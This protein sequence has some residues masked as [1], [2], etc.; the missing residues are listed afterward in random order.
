MTTLHRF[1][2]QVIRFLTPRRDCSSRSKDEGQVSETSHRCVSPSVLCPPCSFV[3]WVFV[4]FFLCV[5]GPLYFSPKCS[6]HFHRLYHNTRDC[7]IPACKWA[8]SRQNYTL[9]S[10]QWVCSVSGVGA[11]VSPPDWIG[12]GCP[13]IGADGLNCPATSATDD[14][15]LDV[16]SSCS[17]LTPSIHILICLWTLAQS[18]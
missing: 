11:W 7:T 10:T 4:T 8:P 2:V 16:I 13:D 17:G 5:P 18:P 14:N 3:P 6:K 9:S 1:S 12:T 15:P